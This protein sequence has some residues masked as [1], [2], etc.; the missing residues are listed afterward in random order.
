MN[1]ILINLLSLSTLISNVIGS[2]IIILFSKKPQITLPEFVN[3][4]LLIK[5]AQWAKFTPFILLMLNNYI[6]RISKNI[7]I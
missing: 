3:S 5:P 6:I 1:W 2:T 4:I 7:N